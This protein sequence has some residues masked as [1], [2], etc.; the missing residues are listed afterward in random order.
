MLEFNDDK[1]YEKL[2]FDYVDNIKIIY[3]IPESID[4]ITKTFFPNCSIISEEKVFIEKKIYENLTTCVY[5]N[6]NLNRFSLTIFE[7][8]QLKL[9]NSFN[10]KKAEDVLYYVLFCME[11]LNLSTIKTPVVLFGNIDYNDKIYELMFNYIKD[12]SFG[13]IDKNLGLNL[14]KDRHKYFSLL[15]QILCV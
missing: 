7:N 6:F 5:L 10:Y 2:Y 12:I 8:K 4:N 13:D 15:S 1:C 3:S 11:Q 9:Q 14:K